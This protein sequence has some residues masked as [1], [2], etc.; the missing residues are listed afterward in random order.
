M[1]YEAQFVAAAAAAAAATPVEA[2]KISTGFSWS[3]IPRWHEGTFHFSDMY[4][5]K[6][7]KLDQDGKPSTWIDASDRV[8]VSP[9]A[10]STET[11]TSEVVLGGL[12]WLPDGRALVVSMHERLLL[13]Y[14]G[15]SLET[16]ADLRGTAI[17]SCN[18]MVVDADG[19]AYITQLGFDL[20]AGEEPREA[21]VIIVEP[22][23]TVGST[24]DV[25]FAGGNGIAL[26][27]DGRSLFVAENS[28]NRIAVMDRAEDG[29]LS[30]RRTW[31]ET[32]WM[33]DGIALDNA[34]GIW[35]GM[36]GCGWVGRFVEGGEAT[37]AV[38][39][40]MDQGMGTAVMLGGDD[41]STLYVAC[42]LE[43]F[44]WAKSR[45]EGQGSIWTAPAPYSA[46]TTR[47]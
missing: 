18:D 11:G 2:T 23:G 8:P 39:I 21:Q 10:G 45:T 7:L 31:A 27:E 13:A 34:G 37:H 1:D 14:D 24:G 5:H 25:T 17:S 20:F 16:Y 42:G 29:S 35:V 4:N 36:P 41:R 15:T 28:A 12:G 47:P 46:G 33:P 9:E 3:E 43:V 22:D 26:S 44:D 30:N 32:P 6:I 38:Q 19:R 40:P